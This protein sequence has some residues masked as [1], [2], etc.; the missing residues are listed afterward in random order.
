VIGPL[1]ELFEEPA[2]VGE[3]GQHIVAGQ[4]MGLEFGLFAPGHLPAH[5]DEAAPREDNRNQAEAKAEREQ[6]VDFPILVCTTP[7]V[8]EVEGLDVNKEDIQRSDQRN[9]QEEIDIGSRLAAV[10]IHDLCPR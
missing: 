9:D 5:I 6:L 1:R 2:T 8:D 3:S 10:P 7:M 4:P